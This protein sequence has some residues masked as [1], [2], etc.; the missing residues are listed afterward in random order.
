MPIRKANLAQSYRIEGFERARD[1]AH[2]W[3]NAPPLVT[4]QQLRVWR[5]ALGLTFREMERRT[6]VNKLT[7]CIWERGGRNREGSRMGQVIPRW[8]GLVMYN[9]ALQDGKRLPVLDGLEQVPYYE[10]LGLFSY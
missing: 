8:V 4:P 7:W 6:G 2:P 3:L 1:D 9:L 5:K 10:G